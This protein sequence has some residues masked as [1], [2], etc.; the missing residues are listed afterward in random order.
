MKYYYVP[1]VLRYFNYGLNWKYD[2]DNRNLM[3]ANSILQAQEEA[4][5][6]FECEKQKNLQFNEEDFSL[7]MVSSQQRKEL[8]SRYPQEE[9]LMEIEQEPKLYVLKDKKAWVKTP[10][11][12]NYSRE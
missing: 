12:V 11:K 9:L 3:K 6:I 7:F 4:S 5:K 1:I 2:F 10:V 8:S